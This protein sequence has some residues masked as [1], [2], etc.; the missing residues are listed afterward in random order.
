MLPPNVLTY[1]LL[2]ESNF[3]VFLS[4]SFADSGGTLANNVT[5]T[6]IVIITKQGL[7]VIE[8]LS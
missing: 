8:F 2:A 6:L 4:L 5:F 1:K 7:N 3:L